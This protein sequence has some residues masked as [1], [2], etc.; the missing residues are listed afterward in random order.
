MRY[1]LLLLKSLPPPNL[2]ICMILSLFNPVIVL[3]PQ[4]LS[5]LLVHLY[6]PLW[7]LITALSV[8]LHLL[9]GINYLRNFANLLLMIIPFHCHLFLLTLIH[10]LHH[11]H[12]HHPS[13]YG[14]M[15]SVF[16]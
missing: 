12:F 5:P 6:L 9:S 15:M 7:K 2:H 13:R 16:L 4:I 3:V 8:T 1:F 10:H 14:H 11:H